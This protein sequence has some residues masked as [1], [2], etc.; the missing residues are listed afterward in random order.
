[1]LLEKLS[2]LKKLRC[3]SWIKTTLPYN[4]NNNNNNN[5]SM[6]SSSPCTHRCLTTCYHYD[7]DDVPLVYT[8]DDFKITSTSPISFYVPRVSKDY[9]E[10]DVI[11]AFDNIGIGLATRVDFAPLAPVAPG[12]R[13]SAE[14]LRCPFQKA[15]V[16]LEYLYDTD[17]GHTINDTVVRADNSCRVYPSDN[18]YWILMNNK[19]AVPAT[20]LNVHQIVENHRI[21]EQTVM[22][23]A[24]QIAELIHLLKKR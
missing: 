9:E 21:L 24:K 11:A 3:F 15:F 12:Q 20:K 19:T 5:M 14:S 17:I 10:Q 16:H 2:K 18:E 8:M 23:Q 22:A 1:M 13:E 4:N 6:M 7:K